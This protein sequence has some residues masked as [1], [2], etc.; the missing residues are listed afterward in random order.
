MN[1]KERK[2][3]SRALQVDGTYEFKSPRVTYC[4]FE[5]TFC[6]YALKRMEN[7]CLDCPKEH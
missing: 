6:G 5:N 7:K 3:Y 1:Q 2:K 4:R